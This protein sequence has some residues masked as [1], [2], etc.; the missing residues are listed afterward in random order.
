[1]ESRL[2]HSVEHGNHSRVILFAGTSFANPKTILP[3][4]QGQGRRAVMAQVLLVDDDSSVL[5]TLSIALQRRGHKVTVA[6]DAQQALSQLARTQFDFLV[7]DIRMP[8]MSGLE[9]AGRAR[10]SGDS[11]RVILT[12]AHY[13]PQMSPNPA[14]QVAEEFFPKPVDVEKLD[15]LLSQ[16]PPPS[17]TTR[18][19]KAPR[20]AARRSRV[21]RFFGGNNPL[22]QT[23]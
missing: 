23:G 8:G 7:T 20:S 17:S 11:P 19:A 16:P 3:Q 14:A 22:P 9:L 6:C 15:A 10:A 1:M 12:S 18:N 13:D 5:L 21:T 4:I 2:D